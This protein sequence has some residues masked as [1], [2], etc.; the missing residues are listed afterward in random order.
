MDR[1]PVGLCLQP[2]LQTSAI[3]RR[4]LLGAVALV[5]LPW[6]AVAV[7][8]PASTAIPN[9]NQSPVTVRFEVASPDLGISAAGAPSRHPWSRF[10]PE[11]LVGPPEDI[12]LFWQAM[13]SG[14]DGGDQFCC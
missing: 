11:M 7:A 4:F 10:R 2:K 3:A 6:P 5:A 8:Q 14:A 13:I 12:E 1:M 9:F